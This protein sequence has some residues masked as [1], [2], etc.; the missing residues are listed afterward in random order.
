MKK[1]GMTQAHWAELVEQFEMYEAPLLVQAKEED[2][3]KLKRDVA[4]LEADFE[5]SKSRVQE[6]ERS[7]ADLD[8][9]LQSERSLRAAAQ[10]DL[11][12]ANEQHR[13]QVQ[14]L[15]KAA[16]SQA[17]EAR[18]SLDQAQSARDGLER[19]LN[20][21]KAD[22]TQKMAEAEE[23]FETTIAALQAEFDEKLVAVRNEASQQD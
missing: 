15:Q 19:E 3:Q 22:A 6:L 16:Q 23:T 4:M 14:E 11:D 13:L 7:N 21:A 1:Q 12:K 18:D 9:Q 10:N 5:P 8:G 20:A 17:D 2:I